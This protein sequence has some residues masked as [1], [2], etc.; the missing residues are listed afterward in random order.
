MEVNTYWSRA[1]LLFSLCVGLCGCGNDSYRLSAADKAAFKDATTEMKRA[2]EDGL[3]A[4]KA[5][6]YLAGNTNYCFLLNQSLTA[7]QLVAVQSAL[8]GLNLRMNEA[9]AKGDAAALKAA[10]ALKSVRTPH[11]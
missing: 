4:D 6:D 2:W 7:E 10:A 9:A 3:K 1:F 8:G 11:R 5:N